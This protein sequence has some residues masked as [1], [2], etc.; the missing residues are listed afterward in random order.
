MRI[1]YEPGEWKVRGENYPYIHIAYRDEEKGKQFTTDE[2]D[3][4]CYFQAFG[5]PQLQSTDILYVSWTNK[6]PKC[7]V[8]RQL[9]CLFCTV[10]KLTRIDDRLAWACPLR[11]CRSLLVAHRVKISQS[12]QKTS[13]FG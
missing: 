4:A 7:L 12:N 5:E 6:C 11:I 9:F 13:Y 3:T 8:V 10:I 2:S 1:V